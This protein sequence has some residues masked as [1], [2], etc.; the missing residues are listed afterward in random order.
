MSSSEESPSDAEH[1]RQHDSPTPS[2]SGDIAETPTDRFRKEAARKQVGDDD[3]DPEEELWQGGYSPSAMIGTWIMIAIA[4][5]ALLVAAGM[6]EPLT[7][8]MALILI[9]LIWAGGAVV[10]ARR[11]L[12]FHYRLTTQ[13]F[14]HQTG[15]LTR[16]TDRIE[17]IDIDDVSYTQG[18]IER[19]LGV[20]T[21]QL[22]GSDRT[23]PALSMQGIAN[24]K[25]VSG[26]IDDIR[27]K[28]RRKR[29]LHIESI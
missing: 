12:G 28:E 22:T 1:E 10:Y 21:I 2:V 16:Q 6:I 15:I 25:E 4:S 19:T 7:W 24:V 29:S 20:G 5:I 8:S 23:H 26:L 9:L 3:F 27:R 13:R 17:V 11:R 14:I 18:P